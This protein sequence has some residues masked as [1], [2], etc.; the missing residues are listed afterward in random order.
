MQKV[1]VII[2]VVIFFTYGLYDLSNVSYIIFISFGSPE[3]VCY[4]F[5]LQMSEY[6]MITNYDSEIWFE[7]HVISC[8]EKTK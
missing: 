3:Q 2:H 5:E 6:I 4:E 1:F 8:F 7:V